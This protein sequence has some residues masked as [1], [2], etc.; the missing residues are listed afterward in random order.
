[1]TRKPA[2]A[3]TFYPADPG[4]LEALISKQMLKTDTTALSESKAFVAPHAGYQFSG[5][6]AAHTYAALQQAHAKKRFD[7]LV[8][9]GPNHTG[10]GRPIAV[11]LE[12]WQTPLGVVKNDRELSETIANLPDMYA[13]EIAH[14]F[15]HSV[16]VQLPFIQKTI[17][18][19]KC[20]F[21][22]MGDQSYESCIALTN[23]I[24]SAA[25]SRKRNITIIA[26][27]DFNH[28]EPATVAKK[29]DAPAIDAALKLDPE[30]FHELIHKNNDSACGFGPVTVAAMFARRSGARSGM[31]L[32][33]ATSGDTTN[34]YSS[35]VAYASIV[36]G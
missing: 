18:E 10:Y 14:A 36:F 17:G 2:V 7:T 26:S 27:S 19:M 16:E 20:V 6:V 24:V 25:K 15:E 8:I 28:Y 23:A 13:D 9:I 33:Y 21:V 31:L 1:M 12:D 30:G 11:S 22:C 3:G 35:V 4:E 34:D 5:Q 29:K 32:K